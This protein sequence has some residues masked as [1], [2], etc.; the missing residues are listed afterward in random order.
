MVK[1]MNAYFWR[2]TLNFFKIAIR[3]TELISSYL[4]LLRISKSSIYGVGTQ[5]KSFSSSLCFLV[6][7]SLSI[8][9]LYFSL[10][11]CMQS[12]KAQNMTKLQSLP[13]PYSS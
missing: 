2:T 8:F 6:S 9:T 10:Y 1:V 4:F 13:F 3:F 11:I 7:N 5:S 12:F